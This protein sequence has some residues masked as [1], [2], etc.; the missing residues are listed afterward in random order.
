MSFPFCRFLSWAFTTLTFIGR[1]VA[2]GLK[3][4]Q[5][6]GH[7]FFLSLSP[8]TL[9][10]ASFMTNPWKLSLDLFLTQRCSLTLEQ[11]LDDINYVYMIPNE[12][13]MDVKYSG[14]IFSYDGG[15]R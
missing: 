9:L 6:E 11:T 5:T 3:F 2:L 15:Q 1:E 12:G 13:G 7:I 8:K 14:Q 10:V 4:A